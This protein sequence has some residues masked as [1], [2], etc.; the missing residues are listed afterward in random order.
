MF[1]HIHYMGVIEHV[2]VT[3]KTSRAILSA[4]GGPQELHWFYGLA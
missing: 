3:D 4:N 2:G 1:S